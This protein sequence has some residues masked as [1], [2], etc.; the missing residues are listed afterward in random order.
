MLCQLEI[1]KLRKFLNFISYFPKFQFDVLRFLFPCWSVQFV[2]C[3]S[4][5]IT[6]F[7]LECSRL[8]W[9]E[10]IGST[11]TGW[12]IQD[13]PNLLWSLP[14]HTSRKVCYRHVSVNYWCLEALYSL[15]LMIIRSWIAAYAEFLK[16]TGEKP[17]T[18]KRAATMDE[19]LREADVVGLYTQN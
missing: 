12:R 9:W 8:C 15:R 6:K 7:G 13:E 16:S 11:V 10:Y 5:P 4:L 3:F 2:T 18:W 17:V 14:V 19:V 1:I